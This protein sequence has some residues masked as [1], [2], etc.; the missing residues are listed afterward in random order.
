[1]NDTGCDIVYSNAG[2]IILTGNASGSDV[3]FEVFERASRFYRGSIDA[4]GGFTGSGSGL[5][6]SDYETRHEFVGTISG[7]ITSGQM[8]GQENLRITVGCPTGVQTATLSFTGG[9]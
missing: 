8:S 2:Q 6:P 4:R 1:M 5:I 3:Q 9:R 7:Q